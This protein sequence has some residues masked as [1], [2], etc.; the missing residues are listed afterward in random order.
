[1]RVPA[2]CDRILWRIG[3]GRD[4]ALKEKQEENKQL[5]LRW[6]EAQEK[7]SN[8]G[9]REAAGLVGNDNS[10]YIYNLPVEPVVE[11]VE[12]MRYEA[13]EP[14]NMSDHKPIRGFFNMRVRRLDHAQKHV[15]MMKLH[16]EWEISKENEEL[17]Q[18]LT[19]SIV[20]STITS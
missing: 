6:V 11:A 17:K 5:L 15:T 1:M 3:R 2:W 13:V 7:M 16:L 19:N 10:A 8:S 4:L 14:P 18:K 9:D 12:L 20:N